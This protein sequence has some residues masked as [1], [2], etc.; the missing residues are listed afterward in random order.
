MEEVLKVE[1]ADAPPVEEVVS[2]HVADE[3]KVE[4]YLEADSDAMLGEIRNTYQSRR[5]LLVDG[6]TA[7]GWPV[8]KPKASLYVWTRV[9]TDETSMAF[10][11]RLLEKSHVLITPGVGFGA[12][13]EGYVRFSLTV[14]AEQLKEAVERLKQAL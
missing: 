2:K 12:S 7:A 6:L 1:S 10:S 9:P 3:E 4:E 14:A 11:A 5:D 13:G 8:S